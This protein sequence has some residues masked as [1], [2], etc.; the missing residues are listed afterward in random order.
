MGANF[1]NSLLE[2]FTRIMLEEAE[3]SKSLNP[4]K[5]EIIMGILSNYTPDCIVRCEANCPVSDLPHDKHISSYQFAEKFLKAIR[6][7]EI[8]PF[9]AVTHNKGIMNGVDALVI[10]TGNDFRAVEACV[11]AYAARNG[12]YTSL[13]HAEIVDDHFRFYMDIPLAIGTVGGLTTLHPMAKFS[14]QLLGKPNARELMMIIAAAGLAQ[15]FS[16]IRS[17][18]TTGIQKGHMKMHLM[19]ILNQLGANQDE[20][21]TIISLFKNKVPSYSAVV[22]AFEKIKTEA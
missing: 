15:N 4:C 9:R 5:I 17:L 10:A 3:K 19:N 7:A 8:E 11:H 2:E 16:A 21:E 1:I 18:I 20:K 12:T 6:I 22:E 14:H 13:S